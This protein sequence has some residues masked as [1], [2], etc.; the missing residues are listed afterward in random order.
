[1]KRT[2]ENNE[3]LV[4]SHVEGRKSEKNNQSFILRHDKLEKT[5]RLWFVQFAQLRR[6]SRVL[7]L[8]LPPEVVSIHSLKRGDTVKAMLV[9]VKRAP[10]PEDKVGE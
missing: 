9:A 4:Q 2:K 7:Y 8:P 3:S 1:M 6:H 10:D 5:E